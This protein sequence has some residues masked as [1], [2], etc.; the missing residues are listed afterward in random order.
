MFF[1]LIR[2]QI[3]VVSVDF[4]TWLFQFIFREPKLNLNHGRA[5]VAA[6]GLS[7][8]TYR[9][10]FDISLPT[11]SILQENVVDRSVILSK[12]RKWFLFSPQVHVEPILRPILSELCQNHYDQFAKL[13]DCSNEGNDKKCTLCDE[14]SKEQVKCKQCNQSGL[15]S[16][17]SWMLGLQ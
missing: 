13:S 6:A 1:I 11:F 7:R 12:R 9:T 2:Y 17:L 16:F 8:L 10:G 4:L 14:G 3:F 15:V 5:M